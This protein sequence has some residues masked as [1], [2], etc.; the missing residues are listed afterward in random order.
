M[1]VCMYIGRYQR[2]AETI[3]QESTKHLEGGAWPFAGLG[4]A[5]LMSVTRNLA[6]QVHVSF[7]W[8]D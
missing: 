3:C 4:S 1:Y 5:N 6:E 7:F 2:T 8:A